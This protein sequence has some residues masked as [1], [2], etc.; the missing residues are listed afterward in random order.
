MALKEN[1][2]SFILYADLI[3]TLRLL[4]DDKAGQLFKIVLEYVNDENPVVND[5]TLQLVFEPIKQQLKRD[6]KAWESEKNWRSLAGKK[7]MEKRWSKDNKD[8]NAIKS[9]NIAIKSDNKDSHVT[10]AISSLTVNVTDTVTVNATDTVTEREYQAPEDFLKGRSAIELE[11]MN[12]KSGLSREEFS[13]ALEQYSLDCEKKGF[14]YSDFAAKDIRRLLSGFKKWVNTWVEN[15]RSR[16]AQKTKIN[17]TASTL[18]AHSKVQK[19]LED[20]E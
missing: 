12:M 4:P 16:P 7:G 13:R 9:D 1:K 15:N 5:L 8:N 11:Q 17:S 10:D 2:R 19:L 6:L 3:H 14:E 18:G 20:G